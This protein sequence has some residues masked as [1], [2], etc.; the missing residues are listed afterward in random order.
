MKIHSGLLALA[1]MVCAVLACSGGN[2]NASNGNSNNSNNSNTKN[3]SSSSSS[4][5]HLDDLYMAKN[6]NG[7]AGEKTT[8]FSPSDHRIYA[9]GKLSNSDSGTKIKFVWYAVDAGNANNEKIQE[10]NYETKILENQ[11]SGHLE[12]PKDWPT[13]KYK[14]E[15]YVNGN[16][17]KTVEYTVE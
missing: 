3:S 2:K 9:V 1:L 16:L 8:S 13:G 12:L 6:D 7:K 5:V 14:V 10:I 11:V 15:A 4:G 17:E